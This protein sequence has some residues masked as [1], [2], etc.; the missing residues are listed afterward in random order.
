MKRMKTGSKKIITWLSLA[1]MPLVAHGER[2]FNVWEASY[3]LGTPGPTASWLN[4]KGTIGPGVAM[5]NAKLTIGHQ[6]QDSDFGKARKGLYYPVVGFSI[7]Y[8]DYTHCHLTGK[9]ALGDNRTS[10][11]RFVALSWHHSQYYLKGERFSLRTSWDLGV[12]YN[13]MHHDEELPNVI[14]PMGGHLQV[15]L[16]MAMLAG[17]DNPLAE[18]SIG[19]HF[20]HMSNS[21]T[22]EPNS[23]A[24]NLGVTLSMRPH[25]HDSSSGERSSRLV[26]D[27]IFPTGWH[28]RWYW[29]VM[30]DLGFTRKEQHPANLYG[31]TTLAVSA[32][33][34]YNPQSAIGAGLEGAYLPGGDRTG[35]ATYA[36]LSFVHTTWIRNWSLHGQLGC[37]LN[38]KHP[39]M[40]D[41]TSRFYERLGLRYHPCKPQEGRIMSPYIGLYSKGDGFIAQQLEIS[42]GCCL[43]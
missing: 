41:R 8:L 26:S 18:W 35:R 33:W 7:S 38:G 14:F 37:Y 15:Y 43:F 31:Q 1:V 20:I 22:H 24:N 29:D 2:F 42:V 36:G 28:R 3:G 39:K 27:G 40:W 32:L 19:P 5:H 16:D 10:F 25:W 23:G 21:N 6:Y 34:Q 11:G 4:Y 30:A 12:A 9:G 17:F 13:F